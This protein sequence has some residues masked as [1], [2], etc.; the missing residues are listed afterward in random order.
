MGMNVVDM[1]E[2]YHLLD[3]DGKV[4]TR[5]LANVV[6]ALVIKETLLEMLL[7]NEKVFRCRQS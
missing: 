5:G 4:E 6:I 1:V 7:A 3:C 2:C